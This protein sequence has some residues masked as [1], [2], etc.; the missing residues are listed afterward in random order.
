MYKRVGTDRL[1]YLSQLRP[2][3]APAKADIRRQRVIRW[4]APVARSSQT[5]GGFDCVT[6]TSPILACETGVR[7]RVGRDGKEFKGRGQG[8][9][10]T[11]RDEQSAKR[12]LRV[13]AAALDPTRELRSPREGRTSKSLGLQPQFWS[14]GIVC[15][16]FKHRGN[17]NIEQNVAATEGLLSWLRYGTVQYGMIRNDVYPKNARAVVG[18]QDSQNAVNR[19]YHRHILDL[20]N[21]SGI[22]VL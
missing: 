9:Q 21:D 18:Q 7:G 12:C 4:V 22:L 10:T 15:G 8:E 3:L 13:S 16:L 14:C 11:G 2:S 17:S 1:P 19:W 5:S 6:V 20:R